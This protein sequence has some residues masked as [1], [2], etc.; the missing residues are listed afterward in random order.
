MS[1]PAKYRTREEVE[2]VRVESDPIEHA[3]ARILENKWANEDELKKMDAEV[4]KTVNDAAEFATYDP[5]PD[6]S[7]LFTDVLR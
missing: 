4:R 2:K 5:E 1:D 7:E 6:P 3:R